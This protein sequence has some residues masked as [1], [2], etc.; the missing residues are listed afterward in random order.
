M[1]LD[2]HPAADLF[3]MLEPT[4][5]DQLTADIAKHGQIEPVVLFEQ[6]ILDG[7]NRVEACRRVGIEPKVR[8]LDACD[9][10][11]AFVISANLH[12]RHLSPILLA[13]C[14]AAALPLFAEEARFRQQEGGKSAGR[15][16]PIGVLQS[17]TD[18]LERRRAT[19]EA[20]KAF[21]AGERAVASLAALQRKAPEVF[22]AA[23]AG[24][25]PTVTDA[26]RIGKLEP[27][28]RA[29][30]LQAL[31]SGVAMRHAFANQ[32]RADRIERVAQISSGNSPLTGELGRFPVIY[33]DPPWRY[34]HV[35][36]ESRAI[37]NQYPTMDLEE[38]CALPV[39]EIATD[40]AILFLWATSP[41]LAESMR[42]IDAWGFTYRTCMAWVKDKIGMGYYARQ[43]HELLL[44]AAKGSLPV[45][46]P[47]NR[48]DSVIES[49]LGEH[50]A[51]PAVFAEL[52]ERMY[53]E[54]KRIELFCRSP[55]AGWA[56]WGNQAEGKDS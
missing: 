41:K 35:K 12:R 8:E 25:I 27:E 30:V 3:P 34:E 49:P 33:G 4:E 22:A 46:L 17:A 19:D 9:S 36:T 21:H 54:H 55:R 23:K 43:R 37:E 44:I 1:N 2:V 28:A 10:P 39:R 42:V 18:L 6:K 47:A 52:I 5:L 45:P 7:R 20:A 16:R 40:D 50:S 53:P 11:T 29:S 26:L 48:P 14:A 51:K 32:A 56:A 38:I 13:S 31:D 24:K 15:G